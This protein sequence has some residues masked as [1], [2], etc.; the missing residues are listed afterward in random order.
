[1][2][3]KRFE[4]L[5]EGLS[6]E[7]LMSIKKDIDSHGISTRK[8]VDESLKK[9]MR[10]FDKSCAVCLSEL[11]FYST[12]NYTLLFGPDDFKKKASFCGLDCLEY[13]IGHLKQLKGPKRQEK[14]DVSE[15]EALS[16]E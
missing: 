2:R 14:R 12:S 10:E 5:L 1:M 9:K 3:S 15:Q 11:R 4:D 6:Y 8:A 13:F 7:E 16:L